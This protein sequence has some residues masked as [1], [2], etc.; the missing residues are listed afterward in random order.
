[1][2]PK[3]LQTARGGDVTYRKEIGFPINPTKEDIKRLK[4]QVAKDRFKVVDGKGESK[5]ENSQVKR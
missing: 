5:K 1:M 3:H 4:Q 2:V